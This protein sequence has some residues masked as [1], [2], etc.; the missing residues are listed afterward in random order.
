MS[1][2][3]ESLP[4]RAQGPNNL[5]PL[6][7]LVGV[8]LAVA[9]GVG[10]ALWS[11][12]SSYGMLVAKV[13]NAQAAQIVQTLEAAGIPH[14]LDGGAVLVPVESL[15]EARLKLAAQGLDSNDGGF[16]A[17]QKDP[18]FGVSQFMEDARY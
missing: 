9:A 1:A 15:S 8:A 17:M 2:T 6:L 3:A 11:K 13:S 7:L 10:V 5:R 18:G 14:R 16:D 12:E 4:I